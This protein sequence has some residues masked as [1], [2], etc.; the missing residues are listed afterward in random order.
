MRP[1]KVL[2]QSPNKLGRGIR[3][4]DCLDALKMNSNN[5]MHIFPYFG[6]QE[7]QLHVQLYVPECSK[8]SESPG[9]VS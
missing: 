6:I 9:H 8:S 7:Q 5:S 3:L 2:F 4:I 1:I